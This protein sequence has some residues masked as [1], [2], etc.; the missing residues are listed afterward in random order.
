MSKRILVLHG[1]NLNLLGERPG[2]VA[3]LTLAQ[4]DRALSEAARAEGG[5][6]KSLQSNHE[7]ALI[8]ALQRERG[9]ADAVL[10]D[11]GTLA[12]TGV[13]LA[14]T[15]AIVGG[16]SVEVATN[17][18]RSVLG[19]EG[20]VVG[21]GLEVYVSALQRLLRDDPAGKRKGAKAKPPK[22]AAT[23]TIGAAAGSRKG[24]PA[25]SPT[26]SKSIG[27]APAKS[28][29]PAP[30]KSLGRQ[31]RAAS[32]ASDFLTRALV[33]EK[34]AERLRGGLTPSGLAT[35]ARQQYLD[36][37]GGAAV[38]SGQRDALEDALQ[39]LTLSALPASRL[40]DEQL[41]ELMT[42]LEA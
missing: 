40:S 19:C 31:T 25:R 24:A 42:Q 13:S 35:W 34:I 15:I 28:T 30:V 11:A 27:R 18:K 37:Q 36:A 17:R 3:G 20:R 26:P 9:W 22:S 32:S 12:Q 16:S 6:V 1:P 39:Q 2:D 7:G 29:A 33:R 5:E 23:K 8:D 10:V 21:K 41:I 14:E 4:V 38:E